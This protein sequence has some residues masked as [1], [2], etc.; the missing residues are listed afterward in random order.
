MLA[1]AFRDGSFVLHG[2]GGVTLVLLSAN[3]IHLVAFTH[4]TPTHSAITQRHCPERY[5]AAARN[6]PLRDFNSQ[7][8]FE[9]EVP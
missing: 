3:R 5:T 9:P 7:L 8:A 1:A 2:D 4:F 6:G